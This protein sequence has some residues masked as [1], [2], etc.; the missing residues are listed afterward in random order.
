MHAV[1]HTASRAAV[2]TTDRP[3]YTAPGVRHGELRAALTDH[4][5]TRYANLCIWREGSD[6]E[7]YPSKNAITVAP[8]EL[9]E[10]RDA[11]NA[12]ERAAGLRAGA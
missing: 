4:A 6:G 7:M 1:M 10:L 3:V 11:V 9:P 2:V 5:G 12:L 8:S